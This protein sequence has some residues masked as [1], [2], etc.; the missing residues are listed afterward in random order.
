MRIYLLLM[1]IAAA[2][3]Y[4]ATPV[5]RLLAQ[6]LN[7]VTPVRIRD[8]HTVPTPRLGGVAMFFGLALTLLIASQIEFLQPVFE[9]NL[10]WAIVLCGGLICLLGVADDIWDLDWVTKLVGQILVA[11]AL[12]WQGVQLI[13]FPI[14]GLTIGSSRLS[15]VATVLAVVV[16]INAV[17]W[18]DGLDGLAA[19]VIAIGGGAFFV[20]TYLLTTVTS[21]TDYANLATV[22]IACLVGVCVGFLPHNFYPARIFMGD[23]G[24]MLLGLVTAA[25]AIVVTGQIDPGVVQTPQALPAFVPILL[26]VAVLMLP[27]LDVAITSLR[28]ILAGKSPWH[29]DRTH[30]HHRLLDHGHSHRRTVVIMYGWTAV[31]AFSAAAFAMFPTHWVA[32]VAG[33]GVILAAV[34]TVVRLPVRTANGW[35]RYTR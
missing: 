28:R 31:F 35:R 15:L 32:L 1:V 7:A 33:V 24:A 19:G 10:A 23:S 21:P 9:D 27:L 30:L 16:A 26:P 5:A 8:I 22:V 11:G 14:F 18:V 20:Y 25:A 17:N 34:L 12:A 2:V 13:T 29:A 3:T 6:R 4:L